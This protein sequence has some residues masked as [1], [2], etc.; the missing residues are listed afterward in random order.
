MLGRLTRAFGRP[1]RHNTQKSTAS[2]KKE[3]RIAPKCSG[4]AAYFVLASP[5]SSFEATCQHPFQSFWSLGCLWKVPP[6]PG[7]SVLNTPQQIG[8]D[9]GD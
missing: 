1:V 2:R 6:P 5:T 7:V 3:N 8:R 4:H 9:L